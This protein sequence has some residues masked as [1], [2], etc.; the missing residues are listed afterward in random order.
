MPSLCNL[1]S[2]DCFTMDCKNGW[3]TEAGKTRHHLLNTN[4]VGWVSDF[5][6][7]VQFVEM[8]VRSRSRSDQ[9]SEFAVLL[10]HRRCGYSRRLDNMICWFPCAPLPH[11][12]EQKPCW[13]SRVSTRLVEGHK[14][15]PDRLSVDIPTGEGRF[16][17]SNHLC[18][19]RVVD[20]G[21]RVY[22][23]PSCKYSFVLRISR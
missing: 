12:T 16:R 14:A 3:E 23:D 1:R 20:I 17:G 13:N 15:I 10:G 2:S 6:A 7:Q 5:A 18:P 19:G 11:E 21:L 8:S 22:F 4:I 9:V